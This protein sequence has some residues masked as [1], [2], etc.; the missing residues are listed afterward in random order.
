M[1][2]VDLRHVDKAIGT[3]SSQ[4]AVTSKL[5]ISHF[6]WETHVFR[7]VQVCYRTRN[8]AHVCRQAANKGS[9]QQPPGVST[10]N[11]CARNN[12]VANCVPIRQ[13]GECSMRWVDWRAFIEVGLRLKVEWVLESVLRTANLFYVMRWGEWRPQGDE[14]MSVAN[15]YYT[16][17]SFDRRLM[18]QWV[19]NNIRI[20]KYL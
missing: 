1:K 11:Q 7:W 8:T 15:H 4:N 17:R 2:H 3:I 20:R 13:D 12:H 19:Q 6:I 18:L 5:K 14:P 16:T 10:T 9:P